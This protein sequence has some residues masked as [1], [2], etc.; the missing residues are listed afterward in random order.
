[1]EPRWHL[2]NWKWNDGNDKRCYV[3]EEEQMEHTIKWILPAVRHKKIKEQKKFECRE[4]DILLC[5]RGWQKCT[6]GIVF[7]LPYNSWFITRA[8]SVF[9]DL[10]EILYFLLSAFSSCDLELIGSLLTFSNTITIAF[11]MK[12]MCLWLYFLGHFSN[13]FFNIV[14]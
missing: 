4:I 6:H 5:W 3:V 12:V 9:Q 11:S 14:Y 13:R 8:S 10:L 2:K 1:M 7:W